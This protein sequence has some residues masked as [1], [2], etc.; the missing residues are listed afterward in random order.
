MSLTKPKV[1]LK[2]PLTNLLFDVIKMHDS[3]QKWPVSLISFL[4]CG[5]GDLWP[6]MDTLSSLYIPKSVSSVD[7]SPE[8]LN[9]G[10]CYDCSCVSAR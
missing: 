6:I 3:L 8:N 7:E 2:I 1:Y 5:G 9:F 10:A 4:S